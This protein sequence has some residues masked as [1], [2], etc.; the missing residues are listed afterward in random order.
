MVTTD[1]PIAVL[2]TI[3]TIHATTWRDQFLIK[4]RL[5]YEF[6]RSSLLNRSHV[7]S[8]DICFGELLHEEQR[9]S[10][11]AILEQSHGSSGTTTVAYA[12]QGRGP[13][14]HSKNLQCFCC[15]EY[16]HIAATCPK[17][18]CSYYKK[19]GHIIK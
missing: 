12:A 1:V 2:L 7:P 16:G 14:M 8:L 4:L 5:K 19:K 15:K 3:Q 17:K 9:L 18:F 10:T 11:Q 13:P 6:V